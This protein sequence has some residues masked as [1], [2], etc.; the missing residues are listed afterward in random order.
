MEKLVLLLLV[1]VSGLGSSAQYPFE[2]FKA[3]RYST[4]ADWKTEVGKDSLPVKRMIEIPSFTNGTTLKIEQILKIS[5]PDSLD[6]AEMNLYSN[7]DLVKTFEVGTRSISDPLPVYVSDIDDNGRKDIKILFPNYGCGAFNYYCQTVFLFQK[8]DGSFDDFTFSDICE[9]F[10]NRPER[11]FDNDG[12]FEII[13]QTFQN[14][15]K[16]NYWLFNVYGYSEG[17]LVNLNRLADYPIMIP[18]LSHEVS[19]KIPKK[20][21]KEFA[22]ATPLK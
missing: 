8:T 11:D 16:H 10:E 17:K 4:F 6:Y 15:G 12:K 3:I 2:K 1:L 22:I 19:K 13:T 7:G 9:E 14:Y 5:L 20:K 18:L 21:M